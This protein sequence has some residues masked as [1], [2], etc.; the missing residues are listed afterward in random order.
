MAELPLNNTPRLKVT[1]QNAIASHDA[2]FRMVA[3]TDVTA[4]ED[5]LSAFLPTVGSLLHFAEITNVQFAAD[6][7]DLFFPRPASVLLGATFGDGPANT[8]TNPRFLQFGGRS[9][10]GRRTKFYLF[11]YKSVSSAYRLTVAEVADLA[12]G[13]AMLNDNAAIFTAIDGLST[14]WYPYAN[15]KENDYWVR[16]SRNG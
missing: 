14:L 15:V 5:V 7:S 8:D 11:G 10:G 1:Y 9:T 2:I 16:Q 12:T 6:G 13:I 4:V 3:D